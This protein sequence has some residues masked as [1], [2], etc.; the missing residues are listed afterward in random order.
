MKAQG[1]TEY[2]VQ[3]AVVLGIAL[4]CVALLTWPT[5]S[6]KDVKQS[7][8][9]ISLGLGKIA[10][11]ELAQGLIVYYKFD[12]GVGDAAYNSIAQN[13][14][15][16]TLRNGTGWADGVRGKAANFDGT[17]DFVLISDSTM[18]MT[19]FT[20]WFKTNSASE[21]LI[22]GGLFGSTTRSIS[23]YTGKVNVN[24]AGGAGR[25]TT[26]TFND[27]N[28]HFLAVEYTGAAPDYYN[29][30]V[31]GAKQT[32]GNSASGRVCEK[33]LIGARYYSGAYE[34]FF[35]GAIDDV[36]I[37]NRA[38]SQQEIELLYKNPGYP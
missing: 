13:Y 16:A 25:W 9:D 6:S 22:A 28:W 24:I 10:Y 12:E 1:A 26:N 33:A 8:R 30:Y 5:G 27:N 20:A 7:Q 36:H 35:N 4:V 37:Y 18:G 3:M 11:P 29:V 17:D 31:D 21:M 23:L 15:D 32:L 2:L 38:L 19:M 14:L 34:L